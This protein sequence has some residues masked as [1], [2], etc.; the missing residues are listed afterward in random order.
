MADGGKGDQRR[1]GTGYGEGY[2]RIFGCRHKNTKGVEGAFIFLECLD[3]GA[4]R[5]HQGDWCKQD[6]MEQK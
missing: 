5:N 6:K 1:P 3:C 4:H 2:D